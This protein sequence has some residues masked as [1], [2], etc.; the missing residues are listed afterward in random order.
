M[1]R[2]Q[3]ENGLTQFLS[4]DSSSSSLCER[5]KKYIFPRNKTNNYDLLSTG[6]KSGSEIRYINAMIRPENFESH[7]N[8]GDH[9][10][11]YCKHQFCHSSRL[12][13]KQETNNLT[14]GIS[15]LSIVCNQFFPFHKY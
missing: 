6:S 12:E 4:E 9:S 3:S 1:R 7:K 13:S 10:G 5:G 15:L 11:N 8:C 14:H 2:F